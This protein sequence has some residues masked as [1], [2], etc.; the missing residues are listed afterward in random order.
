[1]T[2][3]NEERAPEL[4]VVPTRLEDLNPGIRRTVGL[5]W[6]HGFQTCD[7]GDGETREYECDREYGY[8]VIVVAP[9]ELIAETRRLVVLL[10][11]HGVAVLVIGTG[12]ATPDATG[13][14]GGVWIQASYDPA[15]EPDAPAVIDV[16][17]IHDRMLPEVLCV[18]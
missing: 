8:V 12:Y 14:T 7:S 1:M 18:N 5:L 15:E 2:A 11:Q 10:K 6:A 9:E 3:T 16:S 17:F 4:E 13:P